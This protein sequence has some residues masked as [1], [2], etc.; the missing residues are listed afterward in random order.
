[1]SLLTNA[2]KLA[3]LQFLKDSVIH[4]GFGLGTTDWGTQTTQTANALSSGEFTLSHQIVSRVSVRNLTSSTD[5]IEGTPEVPNDF[6]VDYNGGTVFLSPGFAP[7]GNSIRVTYSYG[8]SAENPD[9]IDLI[10]RQLNKVCNTK[11]F[12][13]VDTEGDITIGGV[14]YSVVTG[15]TRYLYVEVWLEPTDYAN[16]T[17]RELGVFINPTLLG[18]LPGGQQ[19]FTSSQITAP[20]TMILA[21]N[22]P[23]IVRN[24]ATR[25][26]FNHILALPLS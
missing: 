10:S 6:F 5:G 24:V 19:T 7:T 8:F 22:Y 18:G 12:L 1:M 23:A 13:V 25:V 14:N 4:F 17:V 21:A 26:K 15:P 2:G 3:Y 9:A 16:G 20:G 11:S